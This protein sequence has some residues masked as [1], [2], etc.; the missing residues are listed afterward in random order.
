ME[1]LAKYQS[2]ILPPEE[3]HKLAGLPLHA[4]VAGTE[5]L[6]AVVEDDSGQVVATWA[7]ITA[8][9]LEGLFVTPDCRHVAPVAKRLVLQ[10]FEALQTIGAQQ[11]VTV[12][13]DDVVAA[14]AEK[15]GGQRVGDLWVIP[16]P[17]PA[18]VE[19]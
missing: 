16:V 9:H 12:T 14:L 2:R 7:A 6:V 4:S 11:V 17:A 15:I 10:M 8:L 1:D 13:Q 18:P 5:A 3:F 19:G